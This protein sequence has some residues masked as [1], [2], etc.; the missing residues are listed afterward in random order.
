M[1]FEHVAVSVAASGRVAVS[2]PD[3]AEGHLGRCFE[4]TSV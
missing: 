3:D 4:M 2:L 1:R